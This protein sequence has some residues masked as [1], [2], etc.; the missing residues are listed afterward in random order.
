MFGDEPVRERLGAL[1]E[2]AGLPTPPLEVDGS[3]PDTVPRVR[4]E[5]GQERI[6]VPDSL[7]DAPP[8]KQ[9]WHLAVCLGWWNDP[10]P[11]RRRRRARAL[12]GVVMALWLG[13]GFVQALHLTDLPRAWLFGAHAVMGALLPFAIAA[14]AR[15]ENRALD[16]A[17]L[18]VLR[19]AGHDPATLTRQV[20][21]GEPD[22]PWFRRLVLAEPAPS[23]RVAA[24]AGLIPEPERPLF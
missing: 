3:E 11:R 8:E 15:H 16:A 6:I 5:R 9:I 17:G 22:P 10:T 12:L 20:F 19:A 23:E 4:G 24:A 13:V 1:A 14:A 2:A 21:G 18:Q 7:L